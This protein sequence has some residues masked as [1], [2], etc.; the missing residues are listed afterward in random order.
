[1]RRL[2]PLPF[3]LLIITA[4]LTLGAGQQPPIV[5]GVALLDWSHKAD[6]AT[7]GAPQY[8]GWGAYCNGA[9]GCLNMNR[10]WTLPQATCYPTLL[11]G[12]E[13]TNP[14]PAGHIIS[15]TLAA[16]VTVSIE[17]AC[18]GMRIVAANIHL[19]NRFTSDGGCCLPQAVA[20]AFTWLADYLA[21]YKLKA[22]HVFTHTLGVHCYSQFAADCLERLSRL[23]TLNYGGKFWLTEFAVWG[24]W[25]YDSGAELAAFLTG[26]PFVLPNRIERAYI[27]T[28]RDNGSVVDLVNADGTL[29]AKGQVWANWQP[30]TV[31]QTW[32]PVVGDRLAAYP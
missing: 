12:N 28:N 19:N 27:W 18:P 20:E 10:N 30:P 24:A 9:A 32:L 23:S 4:L 6:L 16:S 1:M 2:P 31:R 25:P 26:L 17:Q 22:G 11:L 3:V 29:T 13:P 21:A 15:A 8:Y 5:K 14:E 7:L